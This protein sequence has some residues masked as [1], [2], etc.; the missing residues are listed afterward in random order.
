M[1]AEPLFVVV[2][3]S[4]AGQ[5]KRLAKGDAGRKRRMASGIGEF[6]KIADAFAAAAVDPSGWDEAMEITAQAQRQLRR[7]S[8]PHTR[9]ANPNCR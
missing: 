9:P 4:V 6:C 8:T 7:N 2:G 5:Q 1:H 3:L